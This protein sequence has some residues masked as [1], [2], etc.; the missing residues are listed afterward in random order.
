VDKEIPRIGD[1]MLKAM[2]LLGY[3][4]KDKV[5]GFEGVA[6][7]ICFDLY[8]CVQAAVTPAMKEPGKLEDSRWFDTSRLDVMSDAPVMEPP[9]FPMEKEAKE[10][11]GG[12]GKSIPRRL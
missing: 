3:R 5:T 8:G 6:A 4:V 10:A 1:S 7:S 2:S 11:S 12:F 9:S